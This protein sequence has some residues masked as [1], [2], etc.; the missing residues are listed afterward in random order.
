MIETLAGT[1]ESVTAIVLVV[2]IW[3]KAESSATSKVKLPTNS[4]RAQRTTAL[5][6]ASPAATRSSGELSFKRAIT[7]S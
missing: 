1:R 6:V 7:E 3:L 2:T 5:P 4:L